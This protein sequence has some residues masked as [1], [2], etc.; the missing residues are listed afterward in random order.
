M[1]NE[2][3]IMKLADKKSVEALKNHNNVKIT[4]KKAY[5]VSIYDSLEF[6]KDRK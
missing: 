6:F 3:K 1:L 5:S 4:E 2:K